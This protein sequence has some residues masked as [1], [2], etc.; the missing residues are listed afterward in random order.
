MRALTRKIILYD[1]SGLGVIISSRPRTMPQR[2][3]NIIA[4]IITVRLICAHEPTKLDKIE[5]GFSF[6]KSYKCISSMTRIS[7]I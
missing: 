7:F 1:Y 2:D 4:R 6:Y 5:F 3:N